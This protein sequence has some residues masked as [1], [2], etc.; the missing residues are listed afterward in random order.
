MERAPHKG[1]FSISMQHP[2][3][4][5]KIKNLPPYPSLDRY[6]LCLLNYMEEHKFPKTPDYS[7]VEQQADRAID[8]FCEA[9]LN[10]KSVCAASETATQILFEN[11]GESEYEVVE[12]ILT[13]N[14]AFTVDLTE[15][16][17]VDYWVNRIL[18]DV[19]DLF[20]G[21]E[22]LSYGISAADIDIM[23]DEII[24]RITNYFE[25]LGFNGIQ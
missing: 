6:I 14:F 9:R 5:M 8:A 10:G 17:W 11:I 4:N 2:N 3:L 19:P 1:V 7:E 15:D 24:G 20:D 23:N 25:T 22:F 16:E 13:E 12:K 21:C 18:E